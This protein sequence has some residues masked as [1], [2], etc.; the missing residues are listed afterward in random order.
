ME[1]LHQRCAGL[2]VHKATVVS[3]L[4]V[5]EG[6]RVRREVAAGGRPRRN[7]WHSVTGCGKRAAPTSRWKRTGF[8]L[9]GAAH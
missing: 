8:T 9:R 4:R 1:V 2:D 5:Q 6:G 3:C 7:S